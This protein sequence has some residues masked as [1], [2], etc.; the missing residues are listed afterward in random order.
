MIQKAEILQAASSHK[1]NPVIIEKDYVLG[2]ILAGIAN[3]ASLSES[4]VFKGGTCLKKCYF[5]EYRFSEDLDF[6][7]TEGASIDPNFIQA[8]LLDVS[9]WLYNQ[10]GIEAPEIILNIFPDSNGKTFRGKIGYIGPLEQRGSFT[11]IKLDLT[12]N[13]FIA[14]P[15]IKLEISHLYGDKEDFLYHIYTYSYEEIFAEKVRALLERAR[16]RDLYDVI[17]LF[18]RKNDFGVDAAALKE[19]VQAKLAYRNL[20]VLTEKT[21]L[22]EIQIKDLVQEWENMLAHQIGHLDSVHVYLNKLPKILEWISQKPRLKGERELHQNG[23]VLDL[24]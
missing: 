20:T 12:Q 13:E 21:C 19:I 18:E 16:P 14:K 7:L 10:S 15:P 4:W 5:K 23:K 2:W 8:Q 3:N 22:A 9:Q 17:N 6:T 24:S 11:R 1:V